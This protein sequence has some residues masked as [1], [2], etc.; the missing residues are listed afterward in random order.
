MYY[1]EI[2]NLFG[3]SETI[4]ALMSSLA[5]ILER[6]V[7]VDGIMHKI[8]RKAV[9]EALQSLYYICYMN[10]DNIKKMAENDGFNILKYCKKFISIYLCVL[11]F[12]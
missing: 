10:I 2:Q 1:R 3:K 7:Q 6:I 11:N 9:A 4:I 5:R 8:C 12:K